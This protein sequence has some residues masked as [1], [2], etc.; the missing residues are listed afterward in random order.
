M[1]AKKIKTKDIVVFSRQF[2]TMIGANVTII[3]ALEALAEQ[4]AESFPEANF[5]RYLCECERREQ[6]FF[7]FRGISQSIRQPVCEYAACR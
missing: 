7:F 5:G 3:P 4:T 6:P 2:S 1:G